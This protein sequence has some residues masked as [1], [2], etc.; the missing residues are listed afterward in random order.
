MKILG[1]EVFIA[2]AFMQHPKRFGVVK[3]T[4]N[5]T[6]YYLGN[7]YIIISKLQKLQEATNHEGREDEQHHGNNT[8]ISSKC[9]T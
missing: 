7:V 8:T 5:D 4:P 2:K 9:S 3:L 1:Y 6:E